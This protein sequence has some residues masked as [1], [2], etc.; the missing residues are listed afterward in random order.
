MYIISWSIAILIAMFLWLNKLRSSNNAGKYFK[1]L[2]KPWKVTTFV[3]AAI[4]MTVVAPYTGDITWDYFD[5]TVMSLL[6][7]LTVGRK[8]DRQIIL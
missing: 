8:G 5:A 3:I 7:Y 6:T 4:G 2:F 1:F